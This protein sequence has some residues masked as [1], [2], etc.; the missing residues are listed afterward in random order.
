M[1][2]SSRRPQGTVNHLRTVFIFGVLDLALASLIM[3]LRNTIKASFESIA[4][5]DCLSISPLA[6]R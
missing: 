2:Q 5:T 6:I 3:R 1:S 4:I